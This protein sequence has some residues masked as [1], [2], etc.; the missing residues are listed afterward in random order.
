MKHLE[1]ITKCL[2]ARFLVLLEKNWQS[3]C[4][5]IMENYFN[6]ILFAPPRK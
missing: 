3:I 5:Q 2:K 4:E 6:A 1:D